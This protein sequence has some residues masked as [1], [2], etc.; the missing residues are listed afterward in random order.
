ILGP[1]PA[2]SNNRNQGKRLGTKPGALQ[3]DTGNVTC[4]KG[5]T[6]TLATTA[7]RGGYL[8]CRTCERHNQ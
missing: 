6:L 8:Y 2:A 5:H 3:G 4:R 1:A 7:M